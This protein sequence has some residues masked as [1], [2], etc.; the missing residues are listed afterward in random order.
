L[1]GYAYGAIRD[2]LYLWLS[3]RTF[4]ALNIIIQKPGF[5]NAKIQSRHKK[6]AALFIILTLSISHAICH[7]ENPGDTLLQRAAAPLFRG[8]Y[9]HPAV[10]PQVIRCT[11]GRKRGMWGLRC[12][13]CDF[14]FQEVFE[15][16]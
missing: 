11:D 8:G 1:L 13:T 3:C 6:C 14:S 9:Y 15:D 10:S 16:S 7:A 5:F 12:L 2:T 4:L